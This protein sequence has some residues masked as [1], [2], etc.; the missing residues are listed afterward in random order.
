MIGLGLAGSRPLG[1]A[2][3]HWNRRMLHVG[4]APAAFVLR[5][6][7]FAHEARRARGRNG[8]LLRED[9]RD[10]K[11]RKPLSEFFDGNSAHMRS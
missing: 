4:L 3:R 7:D 1:R 5:R 2:H 10:A 8:E 9:E 6:G 11:M